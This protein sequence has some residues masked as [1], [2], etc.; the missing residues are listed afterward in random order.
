MSGAVP[1]CVVILVA[2]GMHLCM[3][4][5]WCS[6]DMRDVLKLALDF[7][8]DLVPAL[9]VK[10]YAFDLH[11]HDSLK[12]GHHMKPQCMLIQTQTAACC[13]PCLCQT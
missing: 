3:Q 12:A 11:A 9:E 10:R 4:A 5:C 7:V 2:I 6:P 8:D 13:T 1:C